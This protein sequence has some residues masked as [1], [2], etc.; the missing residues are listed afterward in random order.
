MKTLAAAVVLVHPGSSDD[1]SNK[2]RRTIQ[3]ELNGFIEV[4]I[5]F[6]AGEGIRNELLEAPSW[7]LRSPD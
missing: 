6:S 4:A 5:G 2:E 7:L 1:L 3:A